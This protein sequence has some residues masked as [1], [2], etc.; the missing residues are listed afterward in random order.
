MGRDRIAAVFD[1]DR[2]HPA[3]WSPMGRLFKA[4]LQNL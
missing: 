1:L 3:I 4:D 2:K